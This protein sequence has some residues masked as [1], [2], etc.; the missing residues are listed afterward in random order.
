MK[1]LL[2]VDD[3]PDIL[4]LMSALF[5]KNGFDVETASRK[6]EALNKVVQFAPQV[7]L[8]DVLLSG[9]DGREFCRQIKDNVETK[10]IVVIMLSAHPVAAAQI[11]NYGADDF[12]AKPIQIPTLIEVVCNYMEKATQR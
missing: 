12:L 1:R 9:S 8:L 4:T 3:D 2:I 11:K 7:V 5:R 6:E 10:H